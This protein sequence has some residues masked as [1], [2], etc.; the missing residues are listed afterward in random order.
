MAHSVNYSP[1]IQQRL[2]ALAEKYQASGQ[3][4]LDFLD[5]LLYQDYNTYWDYIHLDTLLSL[6]SPVTAIPDEEIFIMYH[7][8]TELYFKL[9]LHELKQIA[10]DSSMSLPLLKEKV[11]RV[12]R[13][14]GALTHS[15]GVMEEG[16]DRQQFLQFRMA[17]I[18]ASGFQSVQYRKVEM[19]ATDLYHLVEASQREAFDPEQ[20]SIEEMYEHIYWKRGAT[21]ADSGTK[22]LTLVQFERKYGEELIR[23]AHEYRPRNLWQVYRSLPAA[24]QADPELMAQLRLLDLNV[25]VDWPLQHYKTAVRYLARQPEDVRATGGTN[26]QRYLPPRFQK[27]IFYPAL[28]TEQER[29]EWGKSWVQDRLAELQKS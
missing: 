7:Q 13:Y 8:I 2:D 22:T 23:F 9:S 19:A 6:Q 21:L 27:R 4:L 24:D 20:A 15:F 12:N 1:E 28:W 11:A 18:P 16:M 5:G 10:Y 26:W 17:L 29:A 25:N 3:E 14:F